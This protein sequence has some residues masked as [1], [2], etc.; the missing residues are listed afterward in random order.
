MEDTAF[1]NLK[2]LCTEACHARRAC[3]EGLKK[4][5]ASENVSQMMGTWRRYWYDLTN[6][7]YVDEIR[8]QLPSIYPTLKADMNKV[9]IYLNECPPDA[10]QYVRVIVTDGAEPL[11]IFGEARCYVLGEATVIAHDHSHVYNNS[12]NARVVLHDHAYG[13]IMAG[14]VSVYGRAS[15]QG[16]CDMS[17]YDCAQC[18]AFGG[19]VYGYGYL[20]INAYGDV[21]VHAISRLFVNLHGEATYTKLKLNNADQ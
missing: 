21:Q 20:R 2:H 13:K 16:N 9:G 8:R 5:V 1:K 6:S 15:V 17:L 11:H 7:I 4:M 14:K 10:P 12:F 3:T 18:N 19:T